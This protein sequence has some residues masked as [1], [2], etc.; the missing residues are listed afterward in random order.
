MPEQ[1]VAWCVFRGKDGSRFIN[2]VPLNDAELE[3][4]RQHPSTFFGT[5]DRN[6]GRKPL[7]TAIDHFD[8]LWESY[9]KTDR[10][11]LLDWMQGA[12]NID[13]LRKLDQTEIATRYCVGMAGSMMRERSAR[14]T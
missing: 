3:A 4:Y 12:P 8:F 7:V 1:K 13:E 2:T 14:R 10:D 11:T 5:I 9:G 6:A